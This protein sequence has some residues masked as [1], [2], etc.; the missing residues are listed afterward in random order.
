MLDVF[1]IGGYGTSSSPQDNHGRAYMIAAGAGDGPGWPMFRYDA[2]RSAY[3]DQSGTGFETYPSEPAAMKIFCSPNPC[4][5]TLNIDFQLEEPAEVEILLF[6]LA[7][8][9]VGEIHQAEL[10]AGE[11]SIRFDVS[12][13]LPGV[14]SIR[15]NAGALSLNNRIIMLNR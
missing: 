9:Q 15:L 2:F 7:G 3:F 6:D 13:L 12:N 4:R 1:V 14:Y 5:E 8:R 11:H 10:I